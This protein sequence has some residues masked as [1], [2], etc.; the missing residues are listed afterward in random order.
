MKVSVCIPAYNQASYLSLSVL[1]ALNQSLKPF[2]IIVSNDCST[3]DTAAVLLELQKEISILKIITQHVNLGIIGN[4][5]ACLKAATGEFI[6]R[7]DSDDFL[8]PEYIQKLSSLLT[9]NSTAGYAHVSVQEIDKDG[10]FL[11]LRL[12]ARSTGFVSG[13][14]ALIAAAKGYRVAANII[15]FR[16]TALEKVN[17]I[18]STVSYAEDFYLVSS[19]ANAGY[20]NV[21]LNETLAFYRVWADAKNIRIRRK[22]E[23]IRSVRSVYEE[24]LE[25]AYLKRGWSLK[26]L[27]KS[28][29]DYAC[30]NSDSLS[31]NIFTTAEKAEILKELKTISDTN[32]TRLYAWIYLNNL[33][34]TLKMYIDFK[35]GSKRFIKGIKNKRAA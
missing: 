11:N 17:F 25:P 32:K 15:M 28:K 19:L 21:F 2:E 29:K 3:D 24:V 5:N 26:R 22:I 27:L 1:S 16:R 12:L 31:W 34:S 23:E 20:G 14:E 6:V 7:L 35:Y 33:G 18:T 10:K 4:V 8:A 9:E 30:T 13:D